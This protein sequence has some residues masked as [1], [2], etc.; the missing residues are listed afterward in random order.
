[1]TFYSGVCLVPITQIMSQTMLCP[2]SCPHASS[3]LIFIPRGKTFVTII[4]FQ[5]DSTISILEKG[6]QSI[7]KLIIR[8]IIASRAQHYTPVVPAT[9]EPE[10]GRSPEPRNSRQPEQ[11][12]KTLSVRTI[13]R[14]METICSIDH[15]LCGRQLKQVNLLIITVICR[16]SI[17]YR[18]CAKCFI[19]APQF[20]FLSAL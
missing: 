11:H 8:I 5:N 13:V 6:H 17:M 16:S 9:L 3:Q 1:M 20:T 2:K 4:S 18:H 12:S 7:K 14:A 19:L 10:V 15:F